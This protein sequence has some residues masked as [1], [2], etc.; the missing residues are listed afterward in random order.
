MRLVFRCDSR[1][2]SSLPRGSLKLQ[3]LR[4]ASNAIATLVLPRC[5]LVDPACV[6]KCRQPVQVWYPKARE[7]GDHS[8]NCART[9]GAERQDDSGDG[10]RSGRG[11]AKLFDPAMSTR[12]ST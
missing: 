8:G 7:R 2:D 6:P 5:P 10:L 9:N 1:F 12:M 3:N 4:L 11:I